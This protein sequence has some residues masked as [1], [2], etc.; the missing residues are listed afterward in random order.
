VKAE[1]EAGR[2]LV[3]QAIKALWDEGCP[4]AQDAEAMSQVILRRWRSSARRGVH[5]ADVQSRIQDLVVGL[6]QEFEPKRELVG[7]LRKDYECVA[8]RVFP[9]L[10]KLEAGATLATESPVTTPTQGSLR[11]GAS[12]GGDHAT[13]DSGAAAEHADAADDRPAKASRQRSVRS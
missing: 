5:G 4:L 8:E 2:E 7:P 1:R 9:I 11:S 6:I 3:A 13:G 12:R 10:A